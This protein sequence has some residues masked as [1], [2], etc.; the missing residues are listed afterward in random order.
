[1]SLTNAPHNAATAKYIALQ[2]VNTIA[3]V[4][5]GFRLACMYGHR[6]HCG[7]KTA[8]PHLDPYS[9][10]D[11][12]SSSQLSRSLEAERLDAIMI[13][14]FWRLTAIS[15]TLLPWCL[16]NF[17][18]IGKF[19]TRISRLRDFTR[20]C[21]KTSVRWVNKSPGFNTDIWERLCD[22]WFVLAALEIFTNFRCWTVG[23]LLN[24]ISV[25]SHGYH[26]VSNYWQFECLFRR[27]F[28]LASTK[29]WKI[30]LTDPMQGESIGDRWQPSRRAFLFT[31]SREPNGTIKWLRYNVTF[32]S[33]N[34]TYMVVNFDKPSKFCCIFHKTIWHR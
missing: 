7:I 8:L 1:M 10:S 9:L 18:A 15:A 26:G 6:N 29:A 30:C 24:I 28:K 21:G 33:S 22:M 17:R 14:L 3:R 2:I 12:T 13:V 19:K 25:T 11:K 20:S 23:V 27:F 34:S 32:S 31:Y 5:H 4:A 16:S